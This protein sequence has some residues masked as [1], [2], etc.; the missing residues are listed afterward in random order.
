MREILTLQFGQRSN[1]LATHF[2]NTQESYFT[3]SDDQEPPVDHDVHFR[4]GIGADKSETFTPRTVIYDLK[5]G[6]GS[7]RKYNALYQ[8]DP[9]PAEVQG[10]W[11]GS[12]TRQQLPIV[13]TSQ[14]QTNLDLGLPNQQLQET[15]V[16]YWSDFNRVYF[17]PRSIVQLNEYE[18]QSQLMP[19]EKWSSGEELFENLDREFDLIDRDARPFVEEAD[20]MQ[21]FQIF[22]GIDD[23]WGGFAGRYLDALRDEYGKTSIWVWGIEDKS[24]VT[25]PKK[26]LRACNTVR[27]ICSMGQQASMLTRLAT[28]PSHLPGYVNLGNGS[29]WTTSALLCAGLES[30]TLPTRFGAGAPKRSNLSFLEDTL[31]TNGNQNLFELQAT[32]TNTQPHPNSPQNGIRPAPPNPRNQGAQQDTFPE[33]SHL[34]I[35]YSPAGEESSAAQRSHVFAQIECDRDRLE[36]SSRAATLTPDERLRRRL[37]EESVVEVFQ[38]GLQFPLLDSFP[39]RL[40]QT[41][42]QDNSH[43][44]D[45]VA[46]LACTSKM[47]HK[48][49]DL[50]NETF[51]LMA[52]DEREAVYNDLTQ[53]SQNYSIG[54]D[55]GSD[56]G[57]DDEG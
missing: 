18:L 2:W 49:L 30:I 33:P 28:P 57:D 27:S 35:H 13:E 24:T 5:G 43:G 37:N 56:S 19:F 51:R 11:D 46:A 7:L 48:L 3:Y 1:Y 41:S 45:I 9:D 22:S 34:D 54:W 53:L 47:Q 15:D 39:S 12:T 20:H 6:F 8:I 55:S 16:R 26:Q 29:D 44:L 42:Q 38:T 23:A 21:G 40:F 32:I 36:S 25:R 17:H 10:S 50:R 14:Y 4:A 52:L 31:N